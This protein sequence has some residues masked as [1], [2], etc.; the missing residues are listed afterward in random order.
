MRRLIIAIFLF[1]L[2]GISTVAVLGYCGDHFDGNQQFSGGALCDD[3]LHYGQRTKDDYWAVYF[4]QDASVVK[5]ISVEATGRCLQNSSGQPLGCYPG[6]DNAGWV[7]S[8]RNH[9]NQRTHEA[10]LN[11]SHTA[12]NYEGFQPKITRSCITVQHQKRRTRRLVRQM[13]II[14]ILLPTIARRF[15]RRREKADVT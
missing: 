9:W 3:P 13:D 15:F 12:C 7:D 8:N 2:S 14:G 1:L 10:Q 6:F 4:R 11:S 5:Q